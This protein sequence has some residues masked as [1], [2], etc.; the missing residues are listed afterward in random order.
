MTHKRWEIYSATQWQSASQ[1]RT[2]HCG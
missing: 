2:L 1:K